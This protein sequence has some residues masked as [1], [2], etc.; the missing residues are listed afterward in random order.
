M[1]GAGILYYPCAIPNYKGNC[2][3]NARLVV[4]VKDIPKKDEI[5]TNMK[6][7]VNGI[8]KLESFKSDHIHLEKVDVTT[9][10]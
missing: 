6:A 2:T 9:L 10:P 1:V 5:V 3:V 7:W 8:M 4:Y